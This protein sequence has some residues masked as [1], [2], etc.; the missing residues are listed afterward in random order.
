MIRPLVSWLQGN[1]LHH[2]Y[3]F[4]MFLMGYAELSIIFQSSQQLN[5]SEKIDSSSLSMKYSKYGLFRTDTLQMIL[6]R[7]SMI[8]AS[9]EI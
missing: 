2:H 9:E 7:H 4:N 8:P 5:H 3:L 6:Y 1:H